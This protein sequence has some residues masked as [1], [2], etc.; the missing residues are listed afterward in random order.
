MVSNSVLPAMNERGHAPSITDT[1]PRVKKP[2]DPRLDFFRGLCLVT[3]YGNH[4]PGTVYEHLT[5]RNFGLSDAAEGF[6]FM[7]GCAVALAFSSGSMRQMNEGLSAR[8]SDLR[9]IAVCVSSRPS[10]G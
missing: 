2:R 4:L 9:P 7:S 5:S 10:S 6:V 8:S 1:G 3:I